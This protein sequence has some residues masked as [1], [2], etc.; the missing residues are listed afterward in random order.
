MDRGWIT[1]KPTSGQSP[2]PFQG[3]CLSVGFIYVIHDVHNENVVIQWWIL[4]MFFPL[5]SVIIQGRIS[6][7]FSYD[8]AETSQK[9]ANPFHHFPGTFTEKGILL[10]DCM[11]WRTKASLQLIYH[12]SHT[13][14]IQSK[15]VLLPTLGVHHCCFGWSDDIKVSSLRGSWTT[16][17]NPS[18]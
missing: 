4:H 11:S 6:A 12:S 3:D 10:N 8:F 17:T 1:T 13:N 18:L 14:F 16:M 9:E 2:S 15:A 7:G 5:E